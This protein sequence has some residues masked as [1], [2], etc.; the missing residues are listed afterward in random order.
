MSALIWE[1]MKNHE[2]FGQVAKLGILTDFLKIVE[3]ME[4]VIN[5][6]YFGIINSLLIDS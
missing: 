2:K 4:F 5:F 6:V 1:K 3:K